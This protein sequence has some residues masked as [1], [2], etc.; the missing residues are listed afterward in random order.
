MHTLSWLHGERA[1]VRLVRERWTGLRQRMAMGLSLRRVWP[2]FRMD[3]RAEPANGAPNG[4]RGQADKERRGRGDMTRGELMNSKTQGNAVF[5]G[6]G[7]VV[8]SASLLLLISAGLELFV[9]ETFGHSS[10]GT[11]IL[12]LFLAFW[13]YV[14]GL[15][16]LLFLS[17]RWL[18]EWRCVWV[19]RAARNSDASAGPRSR[20][21]ENP[22]LRAPQY[23]QQGVAP[24]VPSR[25]S[26]D[27][28][29]GN[30]TNH[31]TRVA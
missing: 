12:A 19:K 25:S 8:G 9:Q 7:W 6:I 3:G 10:V 29:D 1:L 13:S 4:N 11:V 20:R 23:P 17:V 24:V 22:E 15:S 27:S 2:H 14:L 30:E 26:R 16:V 18:V 31:R 28:D 5:Q 21:L